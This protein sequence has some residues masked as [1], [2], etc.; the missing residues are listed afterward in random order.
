MLFSQ[1]IC[2]QDVCP[3][4]ITYNYVSRYFLNLAAIWILKKCCILPNIFWIF[5]VTK[6]YLIEKLS[7]AYH[8][9]FIKNVCICIYAI[10]IAIFAQSLTTVQIWQVQKCNKQKHQKNFNCT[11][12]EWV[13]TSPRFKIVSKCEIK[14]SGIEI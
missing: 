3:K 2:W 9:H 11:F 13:N 6:Y 1:K 7:V 5:T 10:R 12:F 14:L 4:L 8:R